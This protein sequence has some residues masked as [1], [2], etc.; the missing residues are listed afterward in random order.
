MNA[1]CKRYR[2]YSGCCVCEPT[3]PG[4]ESLAHVHRANEGCR[5]DAG[6]HVNQSL[7]PGLRRSCQWC[8]L[9]AMNEGLCQTLTMEAAVEEEMACLAD[10]NQTENSGW[11]S[12]R[13]SLHHVIMW[14]SG[15]MNIIWY[16]PS[17]TA[18]G[19]VNR[20]SK[21]SWISIYVTPMLTQF[22]I[23]SQ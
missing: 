22:Q 8:G 21:R 15:Y 16:S 12:T 18:G 5:R 4:W 13:S 1:V 6:Q 20:H 14:F 11:G 10:S 23:L 9:R 3:H 17:L 19:L 7:A 2:C